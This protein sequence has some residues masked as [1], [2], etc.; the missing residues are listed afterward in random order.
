LHSNEFDNISIVGN[1]IS[2]E[3]AQAISCI[4]GQNVAAF[5]TIAENVLSCNG[6]ADGIT[7]FSGNGFKNLVI[8]GNI[9]RE[10]SAYGVFGDKNGNIVIDSNILES[11]QTT[12]VCGIRLTTGTIDTTYATVTANN[13]KLNSTVIASGILLI[14][15]NGLVVE[16]N[17]VTVSSGN[18]IDVYSNTANMVGAVINGNFVIDTATGTN[19]YYIR[20]AGAGAIVNCV[21]AGNAQNGFTTHLATSGA[22]TFTRSI[23]PAGFAMNTA[24]L[25][26]LT[27]AN[28]PEGVVTAAIGSLFTRT[29]GGAGT[30]LYIKESGTGN[31]GWIAK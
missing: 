8:S 23:N 16:G 25:I 5:A 31:T 29:N 28:S 10:F 14:A 6:Y 21:F 9:V 7:L 13:V 17:T 3:N 18:G 22:V 15:L 20:A 2:A 26:W 27:G 4:H 30:T 24:N 1:S 12:A 19:A 11:S